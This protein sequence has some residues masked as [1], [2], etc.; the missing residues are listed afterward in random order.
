MQACV[1]DYALIHVTTMKV[2]LVSWTIVGLTAAKF[3]PLRLH[4]HGFSLPNTMYIW[5][6][7]V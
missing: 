1:A 3:D 7:T 2:Q 5:I 4:F 6:Y